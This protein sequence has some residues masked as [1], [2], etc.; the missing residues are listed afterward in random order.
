MIQRFPNGLRFDCRAGTTDWNT[1]Y[2]CAVE[3]EYGL[4]HLPLRGKLVFDIGAH[5]GGLTVLAAVRGA[6]VVAVEPVPPNAELVRRN[7]GLN[8]VAHLVTVI[9]AVAGPPGTEIRWGFAG[10]AVTNAHAFIGSTEYTEDAC[11]VWEPPAITLLQM[12]LTYGRP[13]VLKL[14]C[15]GGEWSILAELEAREVPLIVGEWHPVHDHQRA[16]I[17]GWL[18]ETHDLTYTGPEAGPAGFRAVLR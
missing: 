12:M 1:V 8:E 7:A 2:A 16:S 5:I 11:E 15:E 9:E 6:R 14:D 13:D 17:D 3:D 10:D 4:G 18:G